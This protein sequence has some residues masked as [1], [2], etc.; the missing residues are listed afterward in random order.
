MTLLCCMICISPV[1]SSAQEPIHQ[2]SKLRS[3]KRIEVVYNNGDKLVGRLGGVTSIGFTLNPD[4]KGSGVPLEI[5]FAEVRAIKPKWT[6]GE[7][8]LLAG[9]IYGCVTVALAVTLGN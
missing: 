4:K 1:T 2:I 7:K 3:G 9:L 5:G 6:K 8:W